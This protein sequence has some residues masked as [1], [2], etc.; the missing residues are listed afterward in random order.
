MHFVACLW[1]GMRSLTSNFR[2]GKKNCIDLFKKIRYFKYFLEK[3]RRPKAAETFYKSNIYLFLICDDDR[4][5]SYPLLNRPFGTFLFSLFYQ[6]LS[7]KILY[8]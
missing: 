7:L 8:F 2:T 5:V 1:L 6:I 4:I 3:F